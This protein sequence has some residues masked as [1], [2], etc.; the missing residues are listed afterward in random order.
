MPAPNTASSLP[1]FLLSVMVISLS[2]VMMPGPVT[3]VTISNGVRHKA[4]GVM[5]ALGHGIIEIPLILFIYLG[6]AGFLETEGVRIALGLAGGLVLIFMALAVLKTQPKPL[7]VQSRYQSKGTVAAGLLTTATNPYFYAWWAFVGAMLLSEATDFG[8][9][10]VVTFGATHWL[11]DA[12][13]LL[14]VSWVVF[15]SRQ[16]WTPR[17]HRW[18]FGVCALT[19]AGFGVW[20]IYSSIRLAIGA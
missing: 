18:I 8:T 17:I 7:D 12:A 1:L 9:L 19:L 4:A 13:W 2:G 16:L 15:K 20:F 3:A 6:L 14:L 10:G 11:C 5:V